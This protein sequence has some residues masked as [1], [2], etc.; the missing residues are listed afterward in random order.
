MRLKAAAA[1]AAKEEATAVVEKEKV[2]VAAKE[3]AIAVAETEEVLAEAE[4]VKEQALLADSGISLVNH[5][6][7]EIPVEVEDAKAAEAETEDA[8]LNNHE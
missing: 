2:M 6:K 1:E 4:D 8:D 3:K 5:V 7:A